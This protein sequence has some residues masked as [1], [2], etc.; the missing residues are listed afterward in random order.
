MR[1]TLLAALKNNWLLLTII[2]LG[3]CLRS[4]NSG[5][6]PGQT[7]DEVFYPVFGLKYILGEPFFSVHPPVGTYLIS[8][9]I[10]L[11][12]ILPW[13][14]PV[15]S[16]GIGISDLNPIS[17]RW[18][19]T[20]AGTFIIYVAYRLCMELFNKKHLALLAALFFALD[21][22]LLVDSRFG[23]IN[24]YLSLFG[25]L[26]V[27]FLLQYFKGRGNLTFLF[28]GC[29]MLGLTFSIKWNGL[30][31][32]LMSLLFILLI[33]Y[34]KKQFKTK[35]QDLFLSQ[36]RK[37]RTN[38]LS[39]LFI[40]FLG[41]LLFWL[42]DLFF[43]GSDIAGRH[44]Q[45]ISYHTDNVELKLHPY[46]SSWFTWPIMFRPIAYY[47]SSQ[48]VISAS[49]ESLTVF[50]AVHLFPNPAL[51]L[52][53]SIAIFILS[54][55]WLSSFSKVISSKKYNSD[56]VS[57]TF[58]LLGYY[59][60]FLPW[61]LVS[62]SAFIYHYQAS[63]C[64]SFIALAYLLYKI[65]LKEKVEYKALYIL[66]ITLI[67]AATIYWLPIQLGLDISAENFQSRMW[68]DSWI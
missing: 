27:L 32:W 6:I 1:K 61:A 54:L 28:A 53:S 10:Y 20:I 66:S 25:L 11:Y 16:A 19:N 48:E 41:Y 58:I 40:P 17:Y 65:S 57:T 24:V 56:F 9:S 12:H 15:L 44:S 18:L 45:M 42:P 63:A 33:L 4:F 23:L 55:N 68:L 36:D 51:T 39:L 21:G 62:R 43:N 31:F 34:L 5:S 67:I 60:N 13:T 14:E 22:S 8:L 50:N 29:L 2:F 7:F 64:F 49:G 30:G 38:F 35:Q 59:T 47:F 3:L 52:L 46:S 26:S 37:F